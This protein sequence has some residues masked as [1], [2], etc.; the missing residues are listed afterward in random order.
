[1]FLQLYKSIVRPHLEYALSVRSPHFKK[2]KIALENVQRRA[3]RLVKSLFGQTYSQRLRALGLPSLEYRRKRSDMVEVYKILN[4]IDIIEKDR[5]FTMA[6]YSSTRGHPQKLFKKRSNRN[7]RMNSFSNRVVEKWNNLPEHV[8]MAPS[9]NTFKSRLNIHWQN[10]PNKFDPSCYIA[11]S[12]GF[13]A[14]SGEHSSNA[15]REAEIA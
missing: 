1:M 4:N 13:N 9:L 7:I 5:L 8:V 6:T 14:R 15:P 12:T 10:H 11:H 2:D 3:T